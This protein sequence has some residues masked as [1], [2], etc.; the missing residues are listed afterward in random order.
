ML[1]N[2][3]SPSLL[4]YRLCICT[5]R[6]AQASAVA[7]SLPGWQRLLALE[8]EAWCTTLPTPRPST[9]RP[10]TR[11][12]PQR[13]GMCSGG[14]PIGAA[15]RQTNQNHGLVLTLLPPPHST[16]MLVYMSTRKAPQSLCLIATQFW[17]LMRHSYGKIGTVSNFCALY[18]PFLPFMDCTSC[19]ALHAQLQWMLLDAGV[20]HCIIWFQTQL[21]LVTCRIR[22]HS[23]LWGHHRTGQL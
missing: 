11:S 16:S 8:M 7:V 14:R 1:H 13:V 3:H 4:V 22:Y 2:M 9:S 10:P 17:C 19:S 21:I 6:T 15:K 18:P 23:H 5:L 20:S 12:D